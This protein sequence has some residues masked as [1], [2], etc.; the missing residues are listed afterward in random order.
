MHAKNQHVFFNYIIICCDDILNYVT[1]FDVHMF[2]F[3][4][5]YVKTQNIYFTFCRVEKYKLLSIPNYKI[6]LSCLTCIDGTKKLNE[7]HQ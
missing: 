3:S 2:V 4:D 1:H 6:S 5:A 7:L